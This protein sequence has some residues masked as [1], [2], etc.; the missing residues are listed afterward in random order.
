MNG[1]VVT[2]YFTKDAATAAVMNG[3]VTASY[4]P[5]AGGSLTGQVNTNNAVNYTATGNI[6][7]YQAN[8]CY[9]V[10]NSTGLFFIC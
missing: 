8:G 4:L 2:N 1:T 6:S 7:Y 5:L 10:S 9:Q 3:T